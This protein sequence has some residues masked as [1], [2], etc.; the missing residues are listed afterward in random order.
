MLSFSV[1]SSGSRA[2]ALVVLSPN[3]RLLIDCGLSAREAANRLKG[4]GI[5]PESIEYIL[6]THEHSDHVKGI[7][8]FAKR[9]ATKIVA[10]EHTWN[11]SPELSQ[12]C[13]TMRKE[14][15]SGDLLELGDITVRPVAISHDAVDPVSFFLSCAGLRLG[16]VTDLGHVT[17]LI[18]SE[19]RGLH[20]LVL[21]SN[22]DPELL[23]QAPYP[24]EVKQRIRGRFGHLSNEQA[25]EFL[26]EIADE[27]TVDGSHPLGR[28]IAA[29]I[30]E[31]S[32]TPELA[33]QNLRDGWRKGKAWL[34]R[35][36]EPEISAAG[37]L[38]ATPLYN[39]GSKEFEPGFVSNKT[40]Q[41][42]F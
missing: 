9:F 42:G 24:W 8:N 7:V 40:V 22:H 35:G 38:A 28:I 4:L 39:V 14:F 20:A 27:E 36:Y 32:N 19:V 37:V 15:R 5:V 16:V 30:S 29:H 6:V 23:L 31:K 18:R 33:V 13:P 25:S 12:I 10:S 41:E 26:A 11:A 3:I 17:T 1:L 21:E 2:N 34:E